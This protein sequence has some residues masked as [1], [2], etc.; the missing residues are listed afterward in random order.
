[1]E[2]KADVTLL[3]I[4]LVTTNSVSWDLNETTCTHA[5]AHTLKHA[6]AYIHLPWQSRQGKHLSL[7]R[8]KKERKSTGINENVLKTWH[9]KLFALHSRLCGAHVYI[10]FFQ[11]GRSILCN[12]SVFALCV[13]RTQRASSP[14]TTPD[15]G[16]REHRKDGEM[17]G[18]L[19]F[20]WGLQRGESSWVGL[21]L[22]FQSMDFDETL[23][24]IR[25]L[26]ILIKPS[27]L[28]LL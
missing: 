9:C 10:N 19:T 6:K 17:G 27:L 2:T 24:N 15:E 4:L 5:H 12:L 25:S 14:T 20:S 28:P 23:L 3:Q 11:D 18:Y 7:E 16:C 26:E 22:C 1:M 13:L 21:W 8:E